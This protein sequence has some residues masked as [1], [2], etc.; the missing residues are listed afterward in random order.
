MTSKCN[1][2]KEN[3]K[4]KH[5][6]GVM[7]E[8]DQE[9]SETPRIADWEH[10]TWFKHHS[11]DIPTP[12]IPSPPPKTFIAS[13]GGT[14]TSPTPLLTPVDAFR[15]PAASP[16]PPPLVTPHGLAFHSPP[17]S[18]AMRIASPDLPTSPLATI[19]WESTYSSPPNQLVAEGHCYAWRNESPLVNFH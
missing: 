1:R 9:G 8:E 16:S 11:F 4:E 19:C 18:N 2:K 15:P 7:R 10:S 17:V 3:D 6:L 12:Q 5:L 14:A 13:P